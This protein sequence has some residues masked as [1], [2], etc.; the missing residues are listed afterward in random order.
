M[1]TASKAWLVL[2]GKND[3]LKTSIK[4]RTITIEKIHLNFGCINAITSWRYR[5]SHDRNPPI[6]NASKQ[7]GV[8]I[9]TH[10]FLLTKI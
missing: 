1:V 7:A 8:N 2:V 9:A 5:I 10:Q 3:K 4:K 6:A